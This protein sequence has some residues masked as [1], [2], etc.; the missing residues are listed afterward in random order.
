MNNS[1]QFALIC[2]RT[3]RMKFC[4]LKYFLRFI[5]IYSLVLLSWALLLKE[6][7]EVLLA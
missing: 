3:G 1:G 4:I 2:V 6:Q 7:P 5:Q